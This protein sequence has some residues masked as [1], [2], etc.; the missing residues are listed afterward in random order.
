MREELVS[1]VFGGE[2]LTTFS[3]SRSSANSSRGPST[4]IF[5]ISQRSY[6]RVPQAV[7]AEIWEECGHFAT[8]TFGSAYTASVSDSYW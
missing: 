8:A 4:K 7:R 1:Q 3:L 5:S 2:G 6:C